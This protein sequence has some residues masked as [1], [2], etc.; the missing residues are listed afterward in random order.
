MK[1]L[2]IQLLS[3]PLMALLV[4]G[5]AQQSAAV[6]SEADAVDPDVARG[7]EQMIAAFDAGWVRFLA[8]GGVDEILDQQPPTQPG[9]ARSYVVKMADCLPNP[10]VTPFPEEPVGLLKKVLDE[11]KIRRL[12]QDVPLN[13]KNTAFYFSQ[14]TDGYLEGV[15]NEIEQFYGVELEVVD[16]PYPPGRLPV[17][18][19]LVNDEA[20]FISQLNATGGT[21]QGMRRRASRRWG[22]TM[23]ASSQFIHIPETSELAAEI[24]TWPDLVARPDV[25]ICAG[26]LTTQTARAF[27]KEHSVQTRYIN[28]L[29]GCVRQIE[30]G[31]A[32]IIINP[33]HDLNVAGIDGF[34]SVH[35]LIVAG[36]PLWV[37]REGIECEDDGDPKTEDECFATNPL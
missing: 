24:N 37:A 22:C 25:R 16:V 13:E 8:A 6:Q 5:C 28:D 11:G 33:L 23:G 12:I 1:K 15:I 29:T 10:D 30:K 14:I 7:R 21:T 2:L 26:P 36:T 31:K 35:T 9:A 27:L 18:S 20:D 17:T 32:D 34:K 3:L 4:T 19:I